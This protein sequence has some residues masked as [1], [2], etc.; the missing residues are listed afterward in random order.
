MDRERILLTPGP[1]TTTLRTKLAMLRDWGS[2]DGDFNAVTARVRKSLLKV[3][4]GEDSHVVVPL[5]GSGTFSVEAAVAKTLADG[6]KGADLGGGAGTAEIGAA[7]LVAGRAGPGVPPAPPG[8]RD[9]QADHQQCT[10]QHHHA[11]R[12]VAQHQT[13]RKRRRQAEQRQSK[14][15]RRRQLA[16]APAATRRPATFC[17]PFSCSTSSCIASCPGSAGKGRVRYRGHVS[18][19]ATDAPHSPRTPHEDTP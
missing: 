10:R 7:V 1:L 6:I 15:L 11:P 13:A 8:I 12:P 4:H 19:G 18:P 5:Q 9:H 3:I 2:W 16:D 14:A 17:A